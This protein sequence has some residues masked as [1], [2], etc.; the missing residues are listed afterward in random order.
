MDKVVYRTEVFSDGARFVGLCPDFRI[1]AKGNTQAEAFCRLQEAVE[2]YLGQCKEQGILDIVLEES[3]FEE[4]G[5]AWKV[6][7]RSTE[8]QVAVL[9]S[10]QAVSVMS[11]ASKE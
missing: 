2:A 9:G 7:E 11:G 4:S 6:R 3:G 1:V 8:I 5:G 10:A